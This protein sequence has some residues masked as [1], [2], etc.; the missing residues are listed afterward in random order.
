MLS[1][2]SV[3]GQIGRVTCEVSVG[4]DFRFAKLPEALSQARSSAVRGG[5]VSVCKEL[6]LRFLG[7]FL[8]EGASSAP[9]WW[10][11]AGPT[12]STW[13]RCCSCCFCACCP[14]CS[15]S[16]ATSRPCTA[17]RSGECA[18]PGQPAWSWT[19]RLRTG[20]R[21]TRGERP[22]RLRSSGPAV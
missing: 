4:P 14:P 20:Q 8:G 6:G 7:L 11:L 2:R 22:R 17:G 3:D 12:T 18:P 5:R 19:S 9:G 15:P 10:C 13:P 21:Q 1:R 16:S